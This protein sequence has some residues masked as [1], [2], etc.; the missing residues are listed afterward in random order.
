MIQISVATG[1]FFLFKAKHLD[2]MGISFYATASVIA[3]IFYFV[4]NIRQ[5]GNILLL[6]EKFDEFVAQSKLK[7]L[8]K[9][10]VDLKR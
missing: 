10:N 6:I 1:A 5:N 3:V 4:S 7:F 9:I 8:N 2:E